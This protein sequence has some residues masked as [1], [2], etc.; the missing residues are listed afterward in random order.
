MDARQL[1]NAGIRHSRAAVRGWALAGIL[2]AATCAYAQHPDDRPQA[3]ETPAKDSQVGG[4]KWALLIVGHPGDQEGTCPENSRRP[5]KPLRIR[6]AKYLD[7]VRQ[8]AA[9]GWQRNGGI[10][11]AG[12]SRDAAK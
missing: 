4:R 10:P 9:G 8:R 2:L 3:V 5:R 7:V 11:R 12:N 1:S 6:R